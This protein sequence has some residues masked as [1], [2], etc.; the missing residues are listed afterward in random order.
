MRVYLDNC[1]LNRPFDD[2]TAIR[3]KLETEAKLFIQSAIKDR[4]I[5]LAWS[6]MIYFENAANPFYEQKKA[7]NQWRQVAK[8]D[9]D[10]TSTILEMAFALNEKGLKPKD[11]LHIACAIETKCDYFLTTDDLLLKKMHGRNEITTLNPVDFV[12]KIEML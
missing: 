5:E 12:T 3:V 4:K 6:Y 2:Q 9:T 1:C 7:I 11:A 8:I 10:E